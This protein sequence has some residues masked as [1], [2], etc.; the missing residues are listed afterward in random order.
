[1]REIKLT[2]G[3]VAIVSDEDY[4]H[5]SQWKWHWHPLN[6]ATRRDRDQLRYMHREIMSPP[7]GMVVDHC[8]ADRLNNQRGNLRVVTQQQNLFNTGKRPRRLPDR[9]AFKGVCG[10]QPRKRCGPRWTAFISLND[11]VRNVGTFASE[12]QAAVAYDAAA[13]ELHG[14]YCC[15]NG[16]LLSHR[17]AATRCLLTDSEAAAARALLPVSLFKESA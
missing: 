17:A 6:F 12:V 10:P 11:K 13:V 9:S 15:I 2:R 16:I 1:M 14:M 8:D 4:E 7:P 3:K 5:L